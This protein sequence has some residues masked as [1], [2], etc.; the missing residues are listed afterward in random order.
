MKHLSKLMA[1]AAL[2]WAFA[3]SAAE[4]G[5]VREYYACNLLPGKTMKDVMTI[6]D[7]L[8]KEIE[9]TGNAD[10][11]DRVSLL[12]TPTKTN[13]DIDFLWFDMHASIDA[14]GRAQRAFEESGGSARINAMA[15]KVLDCASGIVT[16]DEIYQGSGEMGQGPVVVESYRCM[17]HPGQTIADA[18]AAVGYW[19]EVIRSLSGFDSFAG[20]MQT[21]VISQS[22]ADLFYFLVH[23]TI[24]DFATRLSTY[25]AS[26]GGM[27]AERRFARVHRCESALWSGEVVVGSLQ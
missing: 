16:H 3:A 9:K 4:S 10:L 25:R 5:P 13:G 27:E 15:E 19:Q 2:I 18:Q 12:W 17:L 11:T 21:P 1:A 14:M 20:Y 7:A 23:P 6:R 26:P 22:S 8:V 24:A